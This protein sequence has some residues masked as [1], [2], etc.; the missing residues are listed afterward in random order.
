M[1]LRPARPSRLRDLPIWPEG[2]ERLLDRRDGCA[3]NLVGDQALIESRRYRRATAA[4]GEKE[5]KA[6]D[7]SP[8]TEAPLTVQG[9]L[10]ITREAG[11]TVDVCAGRP[12]T[13]GLHQLRV[14]DR[15]MVEVDA[16]LGCAHRAGIGDQEIK[17][18]LGLLAHIDDVPAL[19][20]L[21]L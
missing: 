3:W 10:A 20:D 5:M 18:T 7:R 14:S 19:A 16:R 9:P 13:H 1:V 21:H 17:A 11:R 6:A 2:P 12:G 15:G 8:Q 4:A